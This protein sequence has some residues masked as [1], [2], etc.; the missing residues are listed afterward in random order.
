MR[1]EGVDNEVKRKVELRIWVKDLLKKDYPIVAGYASSEWLSKFF[2]H[3]GKSIVLNSPEEVEELCDRFE[4]EEY[5]PFVKCFLRKLEYE[6]CEIPMTTRTY[7]DLLEK[8]LLS[9]QKKGIDDKLKKKIK[10]LFSDDENFFGNYQELEIINW[11]CGFGKARNFDVPSGKNKRNFDIKMLM[12]NMDNIIVNVEIKKWG[13]FAFRAT[14]N[15]FTAKIIKGVKEKLKD[16]GLRLTFF[17]SHHESI[18]NTDIDKMLSELGRFIDKN[19]KDLISI[20]EIGERID[21]NYQMHNCFGQSENN[22]KKVEIPVEFLGDK[23]H[24]LQEEISQFIAPILIEHPETTLLVKVPR[25]EESITFRYL[26]ST[27]TMNLRTCLISIEFSKGSLSSPGGSIYSKE[28]E[29]EKFIKKIRDFIDEAKEQLP[30][31]PNE[32]NLLIL[33]ETPRFI[34][35]SIVTDLSIPHKLQKEFLSNDGTASKTTKEILSEVNHSN[36]EAV[37]LYFSPKYSTEDRKIVS[38]INPNSPKVN[39]ANQILKIMEEYK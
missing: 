7:L 1:N 24:I 31:N 10:G 16:K 2:T 21:Y 22:I 28:W 32:I 17:Q 27:K 12:D 5:S 35:K 33:A 29:E 18:S 30:N 15:K 34:N 11:I 6:F 3:Q 8:I 23:R 25:K 26:D 9:L 20:Q 39:K 19:I 14:D 36:I 13:G 37:I 38:C 4:G